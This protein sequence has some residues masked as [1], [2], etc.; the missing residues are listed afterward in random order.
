MRKQHRARLVHV[1]RDRRVHCGPDATFYFEN[2]ETMWSQI[3]EMLYIE[4]VARS[5]SRTS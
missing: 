4:R 1:K 2:Y 5:R 3:H